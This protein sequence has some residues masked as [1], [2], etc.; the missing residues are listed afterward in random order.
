MMM[1]ALVVFGL[2]LA[3]GFCNGANDVSKSIATL[4]GSGVTR[5]RTACHMGQCLG[6]LLAGRPRQWR[7]RVWWWR[8]VDKGCWLPRRRVTD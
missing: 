1:M 2:M 7:R 3:V 5:Y 4:V 8:L 6:P